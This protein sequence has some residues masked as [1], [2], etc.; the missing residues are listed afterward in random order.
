MSLTKIPRAEPSHVGV[1]PLSKLVLTSRA[2]VLPQKSSTRVRTKGF[3][4]MALVTSSLRHTKM[5]NGTAIL[6]LVCKVICL[7]LS[8][9]NCICAAGSRREERELKQFRVV[10]FTPPALVLDPLY[11]HRDLGCD[12]R[13]N[14]IA[15]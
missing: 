14:Y 5:R 4:G 2:V 9:N 6:F 15:L 12:R 10:S 3:W 7:V 13:A 11:R 1:S 8:S